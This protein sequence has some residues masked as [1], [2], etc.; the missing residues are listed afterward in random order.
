[1]NKSRMALAVL[2]A[3]L[4]AS[5]PAVEANPITDVNDPAYVARTVHPDGEKARAEA[6]S[7][8]KLAPYVDPDLRPA[9]D[10]KATPETVALYRY[11]AAIGKS[12][13]VIYGHENDAHHK[14]FRPV[15]GSE[16][17]TKDVTGASAGI[18]GFDSLSF[19]GDELRLDD[20]D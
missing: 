3:M 1:M 11:L 8:E 19:T 20:C 17:D 4:A 7:L 12:G 6:A 10:A 16:S 14:M 18:V 15:G 2:G 13:R 5:S 9:A